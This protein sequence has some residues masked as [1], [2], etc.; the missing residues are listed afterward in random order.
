M[1]EGERQLTDTDDISCHLQRDSMGGLVCRAAKPTGEHTTNEVSPEI[2]FECDAGK[3]YR[4]VGC[5]SISPRIRIWAFGGTPAKYQID[6]LWCSLRRRYT[7][8]DECR[9]CE[10]VAAETTR[11]IVS[12]TRGLFEA[13]GFHSAWKDLEAAREA[14]RDAKFDHAVTRSIA[15][16]ESS[17][18]TCHDELAASLPAGKQVTH[19]W[20]STR[21]LLR[22]EEI[23]ESES[24]SKLL[25][26]F[27]GAVTHLGGL[28]NALGDAHG[29]GKFPPDVSESI[30]E[31]C[32]NTAAT[33]ST[34][35]VRRFNQVKP[36][37]DAGN[38]DTTVVP[39]G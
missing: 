11:H 6:H 25:N 33:L 12:S 30:A 7:T 37:A 35:I 24:L 17:M 32:V 4:E 38:G 8:L 34:I 13:Q 22:F 23:G 10:L 2:C 18:R 14:I 9:T 29:R 21:G 39:T 3:V 31:L 1:E 36:G 28:R 27:S 15:C 19:L 26:S 20:K 5:D 16:L